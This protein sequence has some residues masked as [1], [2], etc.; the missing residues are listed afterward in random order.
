MAAY[1]FLHMMTRLR[2]KNLTNSGK[3]P[4]GKYKCS[5]YIEKNP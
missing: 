3:I 1:H 4:P 2:E 5:P